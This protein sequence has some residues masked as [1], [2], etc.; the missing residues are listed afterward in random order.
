[1]EQTQDSGRNHNIKIENIS[2]ERA[3]VSKCR[4]KLRSDEAR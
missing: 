2:F 4:K 1:M 3:E